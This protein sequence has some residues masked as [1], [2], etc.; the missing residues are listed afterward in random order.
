VR[1]VYLLAGASLGIGGLCA[2]AAN[3]A[4][5]IARY[6]LDG[7]SLLDSAGGGSFTPTYT[8]ERGAQN[9]TLNGTAQTAV[10]GYNGV[11][12]GALQ[13][14]ST[15]GVIQLESVFNA[16]PTQ[17][18]VPVL[19]S[20]K[21]SLSVW[22][23]RGGSTGVAQ[24]TGTSGFDGTVKPTIEP[25]VTKGAPEADGA[26]SNQ[27]ANY[28]LG[29]VPSTNTLGV[30]FED[31]ESAPSVNNHPLIGA[32]TITDTNW[33]HAAAT[34]DG[35][36]LRLY[37]DGTI[38]TTLVTTPVAGQT[39]VTPQLNSR[40]IASIGGSFTTTAGLQ[41]GRFGGAMDE[42][43]IYDGTLTAGEVAALATVPEPGTGFVLGA[44]ALAALGQRRRRRR[45][46][47]A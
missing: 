20:N 42:V 10:T 41:A 12:N 33:H 2:P 36:T 3:A 4:Q 19:G 35:T 15:V 46:A 32:R 38:D 21:F 1:R 44:G 45:A 26:N 7:S 18:T 24:S 11:V 25:M 9:G 14:G 23:K 39:T 8:G 6:S 16:S 5:L 43:Q 29:F 37:L 27:D 28:F 47:K 17:N 13:F 22:F 34:Y 30:D 40:Q 31:V